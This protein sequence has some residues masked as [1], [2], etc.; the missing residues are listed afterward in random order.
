M[1]TLQKD[2]GKRY[3]NVD[4]IIDTLEVLKRKF[5]S[6]HLITADQKT[7]HRRKRKKYVYA[8]AAVLVVSAIAVA[9]F[10]WQGSRARR[11]NAVLQQLQPMAA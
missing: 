11:M 3:Q 9:L 10:L 1:K 4:D 8:T 5:D 7:E 2:A 6:G